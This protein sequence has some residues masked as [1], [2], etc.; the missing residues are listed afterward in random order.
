MAAC[1]I[2]RRNQQ[3]GSKDTGHAQ[4][5]GLKASGRSSTFS[6]GAFLPWRFGLFCVVILEELYQVAVVSSECPVQW[7]SAFLVCS[8]DACSSIQGAVRNQI[9]RIGCDIRP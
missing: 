3:A 7:R 6:I 2:P 8:L 5:D 1:L 4:D 9:R